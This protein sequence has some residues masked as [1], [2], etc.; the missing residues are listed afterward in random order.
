MTPNEYLEAILNEQKLAPDSD[1]LE[2]LQTHRADVE[3]LLMSA[4]EDSPPTV[5]YGGSKA[6]GTIIKESYD[7]DIIC[8]FDH[9]ATEAGESLEDIYKNVRDALAKSYFVEEKTSA[10]RLKSKQKE[11]YARDFHVDVVP[12][13][14]TDGTAAD[15]FIYQK[16]AEKCRLKTNLDVH[17]KHVKESSV[18][19][20]I[21]LLKLWKVRKSLN[22]KQFVFELAIIKL[23]EEKKDKPLTEQLSHVWMEL[24]E[25]TEPLAVEDPANPSGNDLSGALKAAWAELSSTATS[26][27]A[28]IETSGWTTVFGPVKEEAKGV[29]VQDL[30]AAAAAVSTPSR[31]W[32]PNS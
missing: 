18:L 2:Q 16:S 1:E 14:Y 24:K 20:A 7:L 13:R 30:R 15:C 4:F 8:Y 32:C 21:Q 23:L 9:E 6:K 31:P 25:R 12:G 29:K 10:L 19:K 3:A 22:V 11:D 27:L 26:T 5:R 17:I 28:T